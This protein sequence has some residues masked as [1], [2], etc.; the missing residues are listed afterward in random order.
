MKSADLSDLDAAR[1]RFEKLLERLDAAM[2]RVTKK[3][4]QVGTLEAERARLADEVKALRADNAELAKIERDYAAL[5]KVTADVSSRLDNT[6]GE[7][8]T[9]LEG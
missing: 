9:V 4:E 2:Q 6:I 8:K 7:L 1:N 5:E 3:A